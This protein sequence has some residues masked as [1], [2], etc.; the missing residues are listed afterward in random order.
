MNKEIGDTTLRGEIWHINAEEQTPEQIRSLG[1]YLYISMFSDRSPAVIN[2][3]YRIHEA[4]IVADAWTSED[5]PLQWPAETFVEQFAAQNG[6]NLPMLH[7]F[8]D[9]ASREIA[10]EIAHGLQNR[11]PTILTPRAMDSLF[12]N[13][14]DRRRENLDL[15][16]ALVEQISENGLGSTI[17]EHDT[18]LRLAGQYS[19]DLSLK[20]AQ[21]SDNQ[22]ASSAPAEKQLKVVEPEMPRES[23]EDISSDRILH[24]QSEYFEALTEQF[25]E[26]V[27]MNPRPKPWGVSGDDLT[28]SDYYK[29]FNEMAVRTPKFIARLI[30]TTPYLLQL[31]SAEGNPEATAELVHHRRFERRWLRSYLG[32]QEFVRRRRVGE[33]HHL[34]DWPRSVPR[35]NSERINGEEE[36]DSLHPIFQ[37]LVLDDGVIDTKTFEEIKRLNNQNS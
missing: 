7:R 22:V 33:L 12:A 11:R 23:G 24:D 29:A 26:D 30:R 17:L 32:K 15:D 6:M 19:I 9:T 14:L 2:E 28:L 18:M 8:C 13:A 5:G 20:P 10:K 31:E 25:Y 3:L 37:D 27:L 34:F 1:R 4:K 36:Q 16:I 35:D 21:G